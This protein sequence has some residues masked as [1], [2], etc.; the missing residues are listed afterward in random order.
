M[1]NRE[2][3]KILEQ[4]NKVTRVSFSDGLF[5]KFLPFGLG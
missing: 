2:P 3:R 4:E 5:D 1:D